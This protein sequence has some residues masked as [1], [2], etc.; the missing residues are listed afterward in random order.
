MHCMRC[1]AETENSAVF[2]PKC[3]EAME[4][5]PIKTNI[6]LQLPLRPAAQPTRK[7]SRKK[8]YAKPEEHIRHLQRSL[9]W[10]WLVL[11]VAVAAFGVTAAMLLHV[12]WGSDQ[13]FDFGIGQNY[14][15][16][17]TDATG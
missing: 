5:D 9:R 17:G 8:K 10:T 15:T 6:T 11:V 2:C 12:L 4:R 13:G 7:K 14:D 3:L 1:G 16:I